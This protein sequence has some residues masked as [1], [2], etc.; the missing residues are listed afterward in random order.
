MIQRQVLLAFE[1]EIVKS[2]LPGYICSYD[3]YGED[4]FAALGEES[5]ELLDERHIL[6]VDDSQRRRDAGNPLPQ[7]HALTAGHGQS[8]ETVR[9]SV[10]HAQDDHAEESFGAGLI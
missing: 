5:E 3:D 10:V 7:P 8:R 6:P 2:K 1:A 4:R 9:M